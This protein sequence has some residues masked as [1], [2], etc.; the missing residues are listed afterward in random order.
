MD[1]YSMVVLIVISVMGAGVLNNWA[2]LQR[3]KVRAG[4]QAA[5]DETKNKI[6]KLEERVRVLERIAT[7][8]SE[9]LKEEISAL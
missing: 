5:D 9:R 1:K 2:K 4:G 6:E 3:E 8:K 7:D